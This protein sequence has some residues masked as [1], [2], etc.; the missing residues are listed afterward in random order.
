MAETDTTPASAARPTFRSLALLCIVAAIPVVGLWSFRTAGFV[1]DDLFFAANFWTGSWQELLFGA[2]PHGFHSSK[3]WRPLVLLTY[4]AQQGF[5][6]GQPDAYHLF[7]YIVHGVNAALLAM[8]GRQVSGSW[9]TGFVAGALFAVHPMV[10][11]NVLWI[12]GRTYPLAALFLLAL[13]VWTV[14]GATRRAAV[15]YGVG[16]PLMLLALAAYEFGIIAPALLACVMWTT[17]SSSDR[18]I[19]RMARHLLPYLVVLLA[20]F[21]FRWLWLTDFNAD[22]VMAARSSRVI[23]GVESISHRLPHNALAFLSRL[24][25]WPIASVGGAATGPAATPFNPAG[26]WTTLLV[27]AAAITLWRAKALRA[28]GLFWLA[29]GMLAYLPVAAYA[30][31]VDRFGYLSI[32][33][34]TGFLATAASAF[35][36]SPKRWQR[37]AAC[38]A[39]AALGL[40]WIRDLRAHGRDWMEAGDLARR[41]VDQTVQ[42]LGTPTDEIEVHVLDLPQSHRS[43]WLFITYFPLAVHTR[44]PLDQAKRLAFHLHFDL[45]AENL[46]RESSPVAEHEERI[47]AWNPREQRMTMRFWRQAHADRWNCTAPCSPPPPPDAP[48]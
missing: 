28:Q 41:I 33:G 46:L 7:N 26:I 23:V 22:V 5:A 42:L 3:A 38:L 43:A 14:G 30:G 17:W 18:T 27:I 24:L 9:R 36:A 40:L 12:S 37:L 4:L 6:H 32:A 34:L 16:L 21:A 44:Y 1:S 8:L 15:Q 11:E 45:P 48:R 10:Q 31:F 19:A 2:W 39:V 20:Y 13:C 25:A 35:L 47:L 29:F